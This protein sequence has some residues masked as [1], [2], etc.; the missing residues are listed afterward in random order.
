MQ[1]SANSPRLAFE[2]P[3]ERMVCDES[4]GVGQVAGCHHV[5]YAFDD[6]ASGGEPQGCAAVEVGN[7]VGQRSAQLQAQEVRE[8]L[9]VPKPGPFRVEGDNE[10]V[11]FLELKQRALRAS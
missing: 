11:R 4:S 10:C 5:P 7:L 8:E 2:Y 9:V 3:P 1:G 6:F